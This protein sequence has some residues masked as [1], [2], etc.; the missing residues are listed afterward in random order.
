MGWHGVRPDMNIHCISCVHFACSVIFVCL[1]AL[2]LNSQFYIKFASK[3]KH[4]TN[5]TSI[6]AAHLMELDFPGAPGTQAPFAS[7]VCHVCLHAG[8]EE[9][10]E[11]VAAW[12]HV[13][14]ITHLSEL[15]DAGD[16]STLE[17]TFAFISRHHGHKPHYAYCCQAPMA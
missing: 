3:R 10:A 1:C 4:T 15:R 12:L 7:T 9:D 16:S 11:C 5:M 8:S 6:S 13:Q 14:E 2:C 17:G